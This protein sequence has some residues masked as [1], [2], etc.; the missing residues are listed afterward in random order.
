MYLK[1]SRATLCFILI[2]ASTTVF[3]SEL[4]S[5]SRQSGKMTTVILELYTS[6]GCRNCPQAEKYLANLIKQYSKNRSF[7]PLEFHVDYWDY[8]G[9]KDPYAKPEYG[10]RQREIGIRNKLNT[11]YTP[12]FIIY[13]RDFPAHKN[14]PEAIDIINKTKPRASIK[15]NASLNDSHTLSTK[16]TVDV[17]TERAQWYSNVYIAITENQLA[18]NVTQGE[19]N[20]S[21]LQHHHVV[22]KLIGPVGIQGKKQLVVDKKITLDPAWKTDNLSLVVFVKDSINGATFQALQS[23]LRPDRHPDQ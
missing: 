21:F 5:W 15:F 2:S 4:A 19:N 12:Q 17:D 22:R 11:L 10:M 13:G 9:W 20:G 6:E 1:L 14:I 7:I 23:E 16:I 18:S 3:A 8:M